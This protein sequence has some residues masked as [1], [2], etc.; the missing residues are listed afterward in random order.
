M[1]VLRRKQKND[2]LCLWNLEK[3]SKHQKN[4]VCVRK[5]FQNKVTT[6]TLHFTNFWRKDWKHF[7]KKKDLRCSAAKCR[8]T[9]QSFGEWNAKKQ[10]SCAPLYL[11]TLPWMSF[12]LFHIASRKCL[13]N[14]RLWSIKKTNESFFSTRV[15]LCS[16]FIFQ[17]WLNGSILDKSAQFNEKKLKA[18]EKFCSVSISWHSE[19][20]LST[21]RLACPYEKSTSNED[22]KNIYLFLKGKICLQKTKPFEERTW[23]KWKF[24]NIEKSQW[25][26]LSNYVL[27]KSDTTFTAHMFEC[28]KK[29]F[30]RRWNQSTVVCNKFRFYL[31]SRI[32]FEEKNL[33][34][35]KEN[36]L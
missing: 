34:K 22:Y 23:E 13:K 2:L 10:S 18:H 35:I 1:L 5:S 8:A 24:R 7:G 16:I 14:T 11:T 25:I 19:N 28:L 15:W 20:K 26:K 6:F 12:M 9:A 30:E 32:E 27:L 21:N 17:D 3:N 31:E 29:L 4:V 36:R 33:E